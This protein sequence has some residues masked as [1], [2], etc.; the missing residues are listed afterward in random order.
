MDI[1]KRTDTLEPEEIGVVRL[2]LLGKDR[3]IFRSNGI[4]GVSFSDRLAGYGWVWPVMTGYGRDRPV[5]AGSWPVM[6]G[7][8]WIW[9][10]L[11]VSCPG[12]VRVGPIMVESWPDMA[13]SARYAFT[14]LII[15]NEDVEKSSLADQDDV[16]SKTFDSGNH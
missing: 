11:A 1:N 14:S 8:D 5:M 16:G 10:G 4:L 6:A 2:Q 9:L 12:L 7:Y 3:V 13:G 15:L